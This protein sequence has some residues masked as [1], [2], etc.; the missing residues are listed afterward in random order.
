AL[1]DK[2]RANLARHLASG[3]AQLVSHEETLPSAAAQARIIFANEFF[4]A[5][6]VEVLSTRG[7]LRVDA[8]NGKFFETLAPSSS[9]ELEFLDHYSAHPEDD[10][11]LEANLVGAHLLEQIASSLI[12]GFAVFVD[13]GYTREEQ[14]SGRHRGTVMAYRKHSAGPNPYDAPGEQDITA[15]V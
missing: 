12:N 1:Q 15:H 3:K 13:Y 4:D 5:L 14:L 6:P 9:E 8:Q 10:E 11:Q 2:L 7:S